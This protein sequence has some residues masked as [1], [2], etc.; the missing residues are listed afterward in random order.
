[1]KSDYPILLVDDE[2]FMRR[3][4]YRM[5]QSIGFEEISE[6]ADGDEAIRILT[7]AE[8]EFGAVLLDLQMPHLGGLSA[9][10]FIRN[11]TETKLKRHS[12]Y[13]ADRTVR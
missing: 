9:L 11:A 1:M 6:A 13:R 3:L 12:R 5:L 8:K 7:Q 4:V 10:R 2:P